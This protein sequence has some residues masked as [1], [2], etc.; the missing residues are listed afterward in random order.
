MGRRRSALGAV[1]D[2]FAPS[3]GAEGG[4][5]ADGG[6]GIPAGQAGGGDGNLSAA[7]ADDDGV[8]GFV[9]VQFKTKLVQRVEHDAGV[10]GE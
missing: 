8:A 2:V 9:H 1:E 5:K 6:P 10:V 7:A 4:E 3:Q